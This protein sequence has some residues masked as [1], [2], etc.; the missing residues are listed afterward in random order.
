MRED[1]CADVSGQS[2]HVETAF[3]SFD[4]S[5]TLQRF[6]GNSTMLQEVIVDICGFTGCKQG[7]NQSRVYDDGNA[8]DNAGRDRNGGLGR[9]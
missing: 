6:R 7:D 8:K 5:F 9:R 2:D 1:L 3:P 4:P